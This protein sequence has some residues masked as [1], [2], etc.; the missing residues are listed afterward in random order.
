M[1]KL[2]QL[3]VFDPSLGAQG[4]SSAGQSHQGLAPQ[5]PRLGGISLLPS[6]MGTCMRI[7]RNVILNERKAA[8][9]CWWGLPMPAR[10][11]LLL[12]SLP[13]YLQICSAQPPWESNA[14]SSF[15]SE[16]FKG[17]CCFSH[18]RL[19]LQ[20]GHRAINT[21]HPALHSNCCESLGL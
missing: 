16:L 17:K 15:L 1:G 10:F 21:A 20:L 2:S 19:P 3:G 14:S 5:V 8:Q 12:F 13:G 6:L 11:Y 7:N 18:R 4:G 9:L